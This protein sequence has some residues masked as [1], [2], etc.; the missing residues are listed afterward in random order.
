MNTIHILTEPGIGDFLFMWKRLVNAPPSHKARMMVSVQRQHPARAY[1]LFPLL[2]LPYGG[3][4]GIDRHELHRQ[5]RR[6][7][8]SSIVSEWDSK[9]HT[10]KDYLVLQANTEVESGRGFS[11]FLT[12]LPISYRL[13]YNTSAADKEF[14]TRYVV[15]NSTL[16]VY[17]SSHHMNHWGHW[18]LK[19]WV[20][21]LFKF[22][23]LCPTVKL[24]HIGAPFDRAL[25][26][27][28]AH[29]TGGV[30]LVGETS[31]GQ[32]VEVLKASTALVGF[33]SGIPVLAGTLGLPYVT[34]FPKHL[35]NMMY[36][37]ERPE[38]YA[39]KSVLNFKTG[40]PADVVLEDIEKHWS[41]ILKQSLLAVRTAV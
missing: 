17:T 22:Q 29:A 4:V 30:D 11:Q 35:E 10:D 18:Q 16:V 3:E 23:K 27:D 38:D 19:E 6:G 36:N 28:V 39:S 14:A 9:P 2:N 31:L 7:S 1:Q 34:F 40:V 41:G 32:C 24:V 26:K 33:H 37:W 8:W 12:D 20:E 5:S 15:P 25:G 21:F 13:S